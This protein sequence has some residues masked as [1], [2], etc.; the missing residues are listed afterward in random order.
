M[1]TQSIIVY[2]N[3]LEAALWESNMIFPMIVAVFAALIVA[4]LMSTIFDKVKFLRKY[5]NTSGLGYFV[6][7]SSIFTVV[8]VMYFML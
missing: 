6:A 3:P 5:R 7:G 1:V 4:V 8:S 2:R